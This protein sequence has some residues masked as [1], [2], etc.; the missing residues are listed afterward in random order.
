[1]V[2][3]GDG[4][5]QSAFGTAGL[6]EFARLSDA[7][8]LARDHELAGAVQIGEFHAGLGARDGLRKR[9]EQR[10]VT[11]DAVLFELC[12]G[13]DALPGRG[14]LDEHALARH[15]GGGV[16][17]DE[18]AGLGDGGGRHGSVGVGHC[19]D[20]GDSSHEAS[21]LREGCATVH[22]VQRRAGVHIA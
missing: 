6:G 18:I 11:T 1:V 9:K 12:G 17:R 2:G 3:A 16:E 19:G 21:N 13:L 14:D 15:A 4:E 20:G 7:R 10:E 5:G 22:G 8:A